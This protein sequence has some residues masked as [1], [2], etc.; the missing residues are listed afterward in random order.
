MKWMRCRKRPIE[1][2]FREVFVCEEIAT[3]EGTLYA[4]PGRDYII[5]G[6]YGEEYPIKIDIFERTYDVLPEEAS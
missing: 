1:V 4:Y 3:M 5:R 6:I 2:E